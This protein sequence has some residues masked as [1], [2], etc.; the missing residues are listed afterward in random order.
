[1]LTWCLYRAIAYLCVMWTEPVKLNAIKETLL[2]N[3]NE[4]T[5]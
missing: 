1:M 2:V 5:D 4:N 3:L